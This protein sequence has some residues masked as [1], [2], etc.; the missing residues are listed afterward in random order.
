[1]AHGH[2]HT[3]NE[4]RLFW[5]AALTG[6]F[7]LVEAIGGV[8]AG[9]LA[10]IA[11]AGHMLADFAGLVLAW[12]AFRLSRRPADA[13]RSYGFARMQVVVAFGNGIALFVIAAFIVIEAVRRLYEP[14][15][16]AGGT[17]LAIAA[18]GLA[19]NVI[20]WFVLHGADRENLNVRGA[21]IHVLGDLFGSVGAIAAAL[22]ILATG[23][24][25]ADPI[26]SVLVAL[27]ILRSAWFVVR[28]SG[29]ILLEG[30]PDGMSSEVIAKDL[31]AAVPGV[32]DVHHVHVWSITQEDTMV[33]LHARIEEGVES[34]AAVAA[35]KAR[36]KARFGIGHATVEVE[37][38]ACAD[39]GILAADHS[40]TRHAHADD[41]HRHADHAH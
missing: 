14:V 29:H 4:R 28:D 2:T 23:W 22:I 3:V 9:S 34:D 32:C 36:L 5:V 11:D 40:A 39:A 15:A 37:Q 27:I 21:A 18:A 19:V 26:L 35:V 24:T 7:M 33:T 13:R 17:M 16:V 41:D 38:G 8:I 25:P 10:L 1:M 6:T 30:T 31:V 20:A 12:L